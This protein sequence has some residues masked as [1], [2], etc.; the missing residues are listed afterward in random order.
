VDREE[1]K[2][3]PVVVHRR[4]DVLLIIALVLAVIA[5]GSFR[6]EF[7]LRSDMPIEFFDG[8]HFPHAKR[9]AEEKIAKAYWSCAVKQ[10]QW[11][12]GYAQRL[13]EEPPPEFSISASEIGPVARDEAVRRHYWQQLRATW[14]VSNAWKTEYEWD[15]ISFRQSLR[16]AGEYWGRLTRNL[17]GH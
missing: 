11:K 9:A 13:P 2:V 12:Y 4:H 5:Y 14:D 1:L 17:M 16:S 8:S 6:S 10:V 15:T 3:A 7:R